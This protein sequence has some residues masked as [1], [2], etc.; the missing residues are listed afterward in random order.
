MPEEVSN[1]NLAQRIETLRAGQDA[2]GVKLD[3]I[4]SKLERIE[5]SGGRSKLASRKPSNSNGQPPKSTPVDIDND[6]VAGIAEYGEKK[7][8]IIEYKPD[9]KYA[10]NPRVML[11]FWNGESKFLARDEKLGDVDYWTE[12]IP[13]AEAE[14]CRFRPE[15]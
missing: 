2:L 4:L 8:P 13:W 14:A 6:Y 15:G 5:S 9:A 7:Y 12:S 11:A 1:E 10:D 3:L